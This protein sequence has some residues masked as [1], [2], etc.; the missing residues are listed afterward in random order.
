MPSPFA[1]NGCLRFTI[2]DYERTIELRTHTN[3]CDDAIEDSIGSNHR[4]PPNGSCQPMRLSTTPSTFNAIFY[5]AATSRQFEP[6]RSLSGTKVGLPPDPDHAIILATV[7]VNVSM[8][9]RALEAATLATSA[10]TGR[11][12]CIEGMAAGR[13]H[14]NGVA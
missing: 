3:R 5:P 8:P 10:S 7:A 4:D 2:R 6:R 13:P 9:A 14:R 1:K 12:D 11:T